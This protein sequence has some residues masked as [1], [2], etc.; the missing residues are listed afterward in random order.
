MT[1]DECK[2]SK[3]SILI[4]VLSFFVL[5]IA[6]RIGGLPLRV[7]GWGSTFAVRGLMKAGWHGYS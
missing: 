7:S 2:G 3:C 6:Q 4:N 5:S 1:R